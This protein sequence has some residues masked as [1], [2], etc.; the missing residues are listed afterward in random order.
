[1]S[2]ELCRRR[3]K[4]ELLLQF[5]NFFEISI[6]GNNNIYSIRKKSNRRLYFISS[7]VRCPNCR[8]L[9]VQSINNSDLT[10]EKVDWY[11]KKTVALTHVNWSF[12]L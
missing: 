3:L 7:R 10:N 12:S 11:E 8:K 6:T 5:N 4:N 1:M 2:Y 9:R